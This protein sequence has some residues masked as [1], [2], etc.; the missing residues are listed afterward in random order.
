MKTLANCTPK[1]FAVQ[2]LKIANRVKN[3]YGGIARIR[4][5]YRNIAEN[6]HEDIF[7]IISYICDRNIDE[8][9]CLCGEMCFM[10]GEEFA[11]LDTENGDEDGIIALVNILNSKRV[12]NFFTTL[13]N[14]QKISKML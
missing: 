10:T 4:E 8:T 9:M 7:E 13:L 6:D 12:V 11:S 1:E 2:T 14:L 5:K 3:Y